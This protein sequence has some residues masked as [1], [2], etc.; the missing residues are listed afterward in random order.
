MGKGALTAFIALITF[1]RILTR[2]SAKINILLNKIERFIKTRY[3]LK[4]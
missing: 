4:L 1:S 3:L 2:E